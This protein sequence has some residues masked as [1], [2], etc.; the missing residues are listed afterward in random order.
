MLD[1]VRWRAFQ[2]TRLG[3]QRDEWEALVGFVALGTQR[4]SHSISRRP[5]YPLAPVEH[6]ARLVLTLLRNRDSDVAH[7]CT[8]SDR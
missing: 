3:P 1:E 6:G 5:G 4:D 7:L 8:A 2:Q